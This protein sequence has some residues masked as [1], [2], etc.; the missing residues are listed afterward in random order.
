MTADDIRRQNAYLTFKKKKTGKLVMGRLRDP[1][2]PKVPAS[3]FF[4]FLKD[5]REK[6]S[7]ASVIE[8]A[9]AAGAQWKAMSK[10]EK[11]VSGLLLYRKPSTAS[12]LIPFPFFFS[13]T[14]PYELKAQGGK[15]QYQ[16]DLAEYKQAK[17]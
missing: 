13:C 2:R 7:P 12:Y 14:Q 5:Y 9:K 15:E 17:A 8:G 10:N 4:M 3:P 16:R 1:A 6:N 11:E